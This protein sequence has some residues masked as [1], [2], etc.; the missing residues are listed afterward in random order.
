M[1]SVTDNKRFWRTVKPLFTEK[2]QTT[3]SITRIENEA[4]IADEIVIAD[5]FNEFL[6]N[7][8]DAI[9]ITPS[10]FIPSTTEHLQNP[11]EIATRVNTGGFLGTSH[12]QSC[13][14]CENS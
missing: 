9:D 6:T 4:L 1:N 2:V 14:Q 3:T 13:A 7:V 12:P 10:E 11:I 5:I 8:I